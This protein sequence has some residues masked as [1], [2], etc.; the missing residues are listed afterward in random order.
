MRLFEEEVQEN[1]FKEQSR[2]FT[3]DHPVDFNHQ[4]SLVD[5]ITEIEAEAEGKAPKAKGF[6]PV[7]KNTRFLILWS[8]Q[9]FSQLAD[10]VYLVLMIAIIAS[11]FQQENQSISG[12]VSAMMIAFTIPA[13]LF[14]SLAGVY[15]DRWSKKTVLV[16]TNLLRGGLVLAVPALL[17][18]VQDLP[19]L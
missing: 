15:V 5:S 9:V 6:L 16:A 14:G 1:T 2:R 10:K 3:E 18:L 4:L 8:G 17:W 11:H 12:W 13:I 19:P 7:L